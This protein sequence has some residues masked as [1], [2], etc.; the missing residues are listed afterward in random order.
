MYKLIYWSNI[1]GR[2]EF[3]RLILEEA[4]V[5]YEEVGRLPEPE[6]GDEVVASYLYGKGQGNPAFGPPL[7]QD[8]E[9]VLAQTA[10]ICDHL[11]RKHGLAPSSEFGR[12]YALQLQLTVADAV[13]EAHDTHHPI[14][15]SLTYE[16]QKAPAAE[17]AS[18][19]VKDR[20]PKF[21][22][23][24][25]TALMRGGHF[26]V[27]D[28]LSYADLSVFQLMC[29]LEYAFPKAYAAATQKTPGLVSFKKRISQRPNIAA[30]L[31]SPRHIPLN[32]QGIFR[33]YPEL[34]LT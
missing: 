32:E 13:V 4:G 19:F 20:I 9:L 24:F 22:G 16:E 30:Y 1:Q 17:R 29:G 31:E 10:A 2:G 3:I 15:A 7:L 33:H 21:L 18:Y 8:G 14:S 25:E 26:L 5:A 11:G 28:N 6:G 12:A 23:Y 34:D 27:E